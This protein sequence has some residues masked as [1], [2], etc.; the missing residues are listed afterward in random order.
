MTK[1]FHHTTI[2]LSTTIHFTPYNIFNCM[3]VRLYQIVYC[4]TFKDTACD[5]VDNET[6][7]VEEEEEEEEEEEA[8]EEARREIARLEKETVSTK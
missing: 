8:K 6:T 2:Y 1:L 5:K 4:F 3:L 7:D